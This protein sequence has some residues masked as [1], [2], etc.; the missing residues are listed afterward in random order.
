MGINFRLRDFS[1]PLSIIQLKRIFDRNQWLSQEALC[2][3]Q[4]QR[5]RHILTQAYEN[6]PYYQDIF[7]EKAILPEDIRSLR[8]LKKIP[9][10]TKDLLR[11]NFASLIAHN[12][13]YFRPT[14]LSTSGTSGRRIKFYTDKASNILEFVYYWRLWGWA[15][16]KLGD[17]FAELS[18]EFFTFDKK[19]TAI[20]HHFHYPT[21]YQ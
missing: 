16:Y 4:L 10:L 6:I 7:R 20:L 17:T 5:M 14:L 18:V 21:R 3:Y 19:N 11:T 13:K 2:D 9:F 15:G 12:A 1:Y 8:D